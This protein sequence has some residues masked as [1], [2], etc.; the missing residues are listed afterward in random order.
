MYVP[1]NKNENPHP[2]AQ[3]PHVPQRKQN[4]VHHGQNGQILISG[5]H[6]TSGVEKLDKSPQAS[7]QFMVTQKRGKSRRKSK[8]ELE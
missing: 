2:H 3:A 6:G 7:Q 1:K 8:V 5:C 4:A